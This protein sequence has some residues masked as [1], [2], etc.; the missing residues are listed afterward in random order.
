[1]ALAITLSSIIYDLFPPKLLLRAALINFISHNH[2]G[3][4]IPEFWLRGAVLSCSGCPAASLTSSLASKERARLW[5][6]HPELARLSGRP[7]EL[8]YSPLGRTGGDTP[9]GGGAAAPAIAQ[10]SRK[11]CDQQEWNKSGDAFELA[12]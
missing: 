12:P 2:Y 1:M 6:A 11:C 3:Y 8:R 4:S 9:G 5:L 10:R 7:R